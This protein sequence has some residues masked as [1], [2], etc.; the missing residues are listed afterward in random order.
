MENN[1]FD[2]VLEL[3]ESF[4]DEQSESLLEIVRKRLI[5]ERREQLAQIIQ[6]AR[7]EYV[8]GEARQGMVDD[9]MREL[10]R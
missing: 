6:E 8:R 7:G 5:E 3:I 1:T 10:D 9:L 2:E 4:P